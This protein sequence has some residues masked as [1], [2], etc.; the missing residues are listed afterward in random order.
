MAANKGQVDWYADDLLLRVDHATDEFLT[1]LAFKGEGYA[2]IKV[3]D[4]K[5][6][7]TG[8]MINTIYAIPATGDPENTGHPSGTYRSRKE[9][10]DVQR[11]RVDRAPKLKP[12][13]AGIHAA[14]EYAVYQEMVNSFLYH[15]LERLQSED[16]AGVIRSVGRKW[17]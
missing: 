9:E 15:A 12:H 1:K 10:R 7:D 14:A 5:Q 6:V 4:N 11:N 2:K 17:L 13:T 8:F 3:R 16:A